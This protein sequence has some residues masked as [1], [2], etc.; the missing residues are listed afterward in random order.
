MRYFIYHKQDELSLEFVN[1]LNSL[2]HYDLKDKFEEDKIHPEI[3]FSVGGDGTLLRAVH[4]H[5]DEIENIS[6]IGIHSGKLGFYCDYTLD[7]LDELINDLK[8]ESYYEEKVRLLKASVKKVNI[9]GLNEIRVESPFTTLKCSLK[10]DDKHLEIFR[11]NGLNFATSFGSTAYNRSLGGP[12]I[13]NN[14]ASIIVTEIAG[15]HHN[16]Y[17][18]LNSPL[19]LSEKH[20]VTLE[21]EFKKAMLGYDHLYLYLDEEVDNIIVSLSDKKVTFRKYRKVDYFERLKRSFVSE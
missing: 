18:A 12:I 10:I 3:I 16:S 1:R 17:H 2:L 15:I 21:G 7:E 5:L 6:F 19:V 14:I 11:G 20:S 9:Y 13:E 8:S 4:D